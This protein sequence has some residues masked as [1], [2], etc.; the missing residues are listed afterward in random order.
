MNA[1]Q[2]V[3]LPLDRIIVG[4]RLRDLDPLQ[5]EALAESIKA[6]GL[7][8]PLAVGPADAAGCHVLIAGYHRLAA[9]RRNGA[10]TASAI[11]QDVKNEDEARLIEIEENLLRHD[12]TELDRAIFLAK[13][14]ETYSKL[15]EA[16]GR[17]R[18]R[19][20]IRTNLS[21]FPLRFSEAVQGRLNLTPRSLDRAIRRSEINPELK[22]A[23]TGHPA[24]RNG[25]VIDLLLKLKDRQAA[26]AAEFDPEWS[27][28]EVRARAMEL[29]GAGTPKRPDFLARII[30]LGARLSAAHLDQAIR[31]LQQIAKHHKKSGGQP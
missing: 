23:L 18:P 5:V 6:R 2:V 9:L 11:V 20:E 21:E 1:R 30:A 27:I 7:L 24:A 8:A 28:A 10:K 13:W 31:E 14:K 29:L 25:S 22:H 15:T 19:K 17:G 4:D 16:P 26:F 3:E 12:L